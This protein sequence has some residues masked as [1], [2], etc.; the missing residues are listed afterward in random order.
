MTEYMIDLDNRIGG[1]TGNFLLVGGEWLARYGLRHWVI[2]INLYRTGF[3]TDKE[4]MAWCAANS[5][6]LE[7]HDTQGNKHDPWFGVGSM[8]SK[9]ESS[10]PI[11]DLPYGTAD[12]RAK[13]ELY[14]SQ[15]L[16][17]TDNAEV[18]K[19]RQ[20]DAL[21]SSWFPQK[22]IRRWKAEALSARPQTSEPPFAG[23]D[24]SDYDLEAFS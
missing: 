21:M 10:P 5:I 23:F 15:A 8:K 6:V 7:P 14:V 22:V 9:Y 3:L 20:T 13:T 24:V 16:R 19:R 1:G 2:E 12:A 17:F 4:V 18:L 11:V